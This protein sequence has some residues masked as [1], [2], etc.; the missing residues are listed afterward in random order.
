MSR[1][2]N[3]LDSSSAAVLIGTLR[4]NWTVA[5]CLIEIVKVLTSLCICTAYLIIAFI[6]TVSIRFIPKQKQN[7]YCYTIMLSKANLNK[8]FFSPLSDP[9][10][11]KKISKYSILCK[12]NIN[13]NILQTK[14]FK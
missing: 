3:V 5:Q 6:F 11:N 2:G 1:G 12:K 13:L 4:V 7:I 14:N 9:V 10:C 8:L